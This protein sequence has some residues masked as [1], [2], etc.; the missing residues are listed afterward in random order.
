MGEWILILCISFED[1]TKNE[2]TFWDLEAFS[3]IFPNCTDW[4]STYFLIMENFL[5]YSEGVSST[6]TKVKIVKDIHLQMWKV[7]DIWYEKRFAIL[8]GQIQL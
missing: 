8:V 4:N 5:A 7:F 2:S 3:S 1:G 6:M